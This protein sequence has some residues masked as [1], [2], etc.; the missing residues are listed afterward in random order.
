MKIYKMLEDYYH[1]P[2]KENIYLKKNDILIV[3]VCNFDS[4]QVSLLT[5][6]IRGK[7]TTILNIVDAKL[8]PYGMLGWWID[9]LYD[10][11][12]LALGV[13]ERISGTLN[14]FFELNPIKDVTNEFKD[15]L[16]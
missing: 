5:K 8:S 6:L 13:K 12:T 3:D 14:A 11:D 15:E 7:E 10:F 1:I 9:K 4:K 2:S 16:L